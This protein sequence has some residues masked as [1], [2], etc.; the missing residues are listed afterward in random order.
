MTAIYDRTAK[1]LASLDFSDEN[2]ALAERAAEGKRL[3]AA[4]RKAEARIAEVTGK[5]SEILQDRL[6]EKRAAVAVADALLG[7]ADASQATATVARERDLREE[8]QALRAGL[9]ELEERARVC[10]E[11]MARLKGAA[12]SKV[13]PALRPVIDDLLAEARAA[14]DTIARAYASAAGIQTGAPAFQAETDMLG[15]ALAKLMRSELVPRRDVLEV[16]DSVAEMLAPLSEKGLA[17]AGN[18]PA[19]VGVP[20]DIATTSLVAAMAARQAVG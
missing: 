16:P 9:R 3:S 20:E 12:M 11:D 8:L 15:A 2:Q 14:A 7:D 5:L 18:V 6:A 4:M 13:V 10:G 17:A 1:A 19:R